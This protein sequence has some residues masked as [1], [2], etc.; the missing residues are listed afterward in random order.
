M[1]W[2]K[3]ILCI[4]YRFLLKFMHLYIFMYLMYH[5]YIFI[6]IYTF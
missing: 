2:E 5:L 6:K 4:I 3:F 1:N